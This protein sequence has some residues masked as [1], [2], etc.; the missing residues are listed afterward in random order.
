MHRVFVAPPFLYGK[1]ELN[2]MQAYGEAGVTKIARILER[3][4]LSAMRLLGASNVSE[5][6]PE[7]VR[8]S[9]KLRGSLFNILQVE[10]V[11]WQPIRGKL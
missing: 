3:E 10:R 9:E 6:V 11:D 8:M 7:M 5:L 2:N 4:I 1:T